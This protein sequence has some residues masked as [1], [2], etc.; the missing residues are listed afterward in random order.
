MTQAYIKSLCSEDIKCL[1][2]KLLFMK[3]IDLLDRL[4]IFYT[5]HLLLRKVKDVQQESLMLYKRQ[6]CLTKVIDLTAI[7]HRT[8]F[9]S[10]MVRNVSAWIRLVKLVL[11]TA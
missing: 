5:N 1:E 3:S 8:D 4:L 2:N 7:F 11:I 10:E 6:G 9:L